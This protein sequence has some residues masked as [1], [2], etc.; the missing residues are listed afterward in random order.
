MTFGAGIGVGGGTR[1]GGVGVAGAP[2][3]AAVGLTVAAAARPASGRPASA[4]QASAA[5]SGEGRVRST[6]AIIEMGSE[7]VNA[8]ARGRHAEVAPAAYILLP[9]ENGCRPRGR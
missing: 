3:G 2:A 1:G 6:G 9:L 4:R 7:R 8:L 5:R